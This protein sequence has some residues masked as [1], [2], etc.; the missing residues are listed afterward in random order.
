MKTVRSDQKSCE[1]DFHYDAEEPFELIT[2]AV[3]DTSKKLVE[4]TRFTTQTIK[5][6]NQINKSIL[7]P[8]LRLAVDKKLFYSTYS[9]DDLA[10]I[11]TAKIVAGF[12]SHMINKLRHN[13]F[14]TISGVHFKIVNKSLFFENE[15]YNSFEL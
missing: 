4:E 8:P 12:D 6:L 3:T 14:K 11:V 13:L 10:E 9:V 5:A 2:K 1:Q 7:H 15:H